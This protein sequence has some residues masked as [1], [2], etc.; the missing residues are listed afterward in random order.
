MNRP[1]N[2]GEVATSAL[3][4]TYDS[5]SFWELASS[6]AD[7][8]PRR[9]TIVDAAPG[10]GDAPVT[11]ADLA[12][13][14]HPQMLVLTTAGVTRGD[15]SAYSYS[16]SAGAS[17]RAVVAHL[18]RVQVEPA[19]KVFLVAT[20]GHLWLTPIGQ[21][22][23]QATFSGL[24]LKQGE[25]IV[26]SGVW[27]SEGYLVMGTASGR[28]KRTE[29]SALADVVPDRAWTEVFGLSGGDRVTFARVCGDK[30]S[31]LF[32]S[33]SK[34]LHIEA[35]TVTSQQTPSARGVVG[36]KLAE[37]DKLLGGD[38]VDDVKGC[39]V[40][41]LSEKGYLKRVPLDQIPTKGRGS[42]GVQSL[43]IT[44]TTG[45]VAAVA[46]AKVSRATTVDVLSEDGKRQRV[47]MRGIPTEN[48]TNRGKKL[49][50]LAQ[51]REIVLLG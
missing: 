10:E 9:T 13:P 46:V 30:G 35:E 2:P 37:G 40:F 24:G 16:V 6:P 1:K 47:S 26:S 49:V 11:S 48:R 27:S 41:V 21:V 50:K 22:P 20:N 34:I 18:A 25:R 12:V 36:V 23:S 42:M 8:T 5:R 17:S 31:V 44:K 15:A 51:P 19:Q 3:A 38:A 28:V 33:D 7:V 32:F 45:A 39:M 14:E 29:M 43:N 4:L